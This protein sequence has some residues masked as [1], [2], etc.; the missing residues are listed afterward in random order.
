LPLSTLLLDLG[1]TLV[2]GERP[3]PHV[4]AALACLSQVSVGGGGTLV[5]A[6][7]SDFDAEQGHDAFTEYVETVRKFGL[8]EYVTPPDRKMTISAQAGVRKPD[9]RI[10]ELALKRL[11]KPTHLSTAGFVSE[12]PEHVAACRALGM[13]ALQ[14]GADFDDWS[15]APLRVLAWL[16]P[17]VEVVVPAL[18]LFF[19]ARHGVELSNV[20]EVPSPIAGGR[21]FRAKASPAT[22]SDLLEVDVDSIGI[23]RRARLGGD[24]LNPPNTAEHFTETLLANEQISAAGEALPPG[25]T[26]EMTVGPDGKPLPKRRRFSLH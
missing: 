12:Q 26:H 14:F 8:L 17:P 16:K 7:V 21:S 18:N 9:R 4:P 6:L 1:D 2:H 20:T 5:L 10:F 13:H 3:F 22:T 15:E 25:A 24:L 19:E 23:V 11:G